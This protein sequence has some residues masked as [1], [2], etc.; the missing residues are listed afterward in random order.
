MPK[1]KLSVEFNDLEGTNFSITYMPKF[2]QFSV[3]ITDSC[4]RSTNSISMGYEDLRSLFKEVENIV[5]QTTDLV[6]D[7]RSFPKPN[8]ED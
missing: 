1:K 7:E 2:N 5:F 4:G 3:S 6:R 8:T